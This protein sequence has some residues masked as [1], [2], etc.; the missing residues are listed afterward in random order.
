[1]YG[2]VD[3]QENEVETDTNGAEFQASSLF[4][5]AH[6]TTDAQRKRC[7]ST[8]SG[9]SALG[10]GSP[11]KQPKPKRQKIAEGSSSSSNG[12]PPRH[13]GAKEG[14]AEEFETNITGTKRNQASVAVT[15]NKEN[16]SQSGPSSTGPADS[17]I[18]KT[19]F[20]EKLQAV[21][22]NGGGAS[23]KACFTNVDAKGN[24]TGYGFGCTS[25]ISMAAETATKKEFSQFA[26]GVHCAADD[27][28]T[29]SQSTSQPMSV[30]GLAP[31]SKTST[32]T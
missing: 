14:G 27:L 15:G 32:T 18:T 7:S 26:E 17:S 8:G 11:V 5:G 4:A 25:Q 1:M 6:S 24:H 22:A 23:S 16:L 19:S 21:F 31:P 28:S 10:N 3:M 9:V 30:D 12:R 13:D 29:A 2:E 20:N